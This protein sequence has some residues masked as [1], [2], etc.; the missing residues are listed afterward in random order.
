[1]VYQHV[2]R[3]IFPSFEGVPVGKDWVSDVPQRF[4]IDFIIPSTVHDIKNTEV[5]VL[6]INNVDR[7]IVASDIFP[8]SQYQVSGVEE[9]TTDSAILI[10]KQGQNLEVSAIDGSKVEVYALDGVK[11]ATYDVTNGRLNTPANWNG[12]VVVKVTNAAAVKSAKLLF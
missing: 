11:L 4:S 12:P 2:S 3:G 10:S 6:I 9:V 7:S 8:A 1:M 5:A